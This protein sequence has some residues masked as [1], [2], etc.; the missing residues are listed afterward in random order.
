M[1]RIICTSVNDAYV[2]DAWGKAHNPTDIVFLADG[3]DKFAK[4]IGLDADTGD[5][6]GARSK[7]YAMVVDNAVVIAL[8]IDEPKQFEV[9]KSEVMLELV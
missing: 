4:A 5:F 3:A 8:N 7:R 6:G 2:M 9:S 1:D